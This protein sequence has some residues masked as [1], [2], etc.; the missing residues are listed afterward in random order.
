MHNRTFL[1][2]ETR[3]ESYGT[4]PLYTAYSHVFVLA[5][6]IRDIDPNA[7]KWPVAKTDAEALAGMYPRRS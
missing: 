6:K 7:V 3:R 2:P 1:Y 4:L 5:R